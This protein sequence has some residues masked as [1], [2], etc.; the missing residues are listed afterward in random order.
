MGV[1]LERLN[2]EHTTESRQDCQELVL[3]TISY[4]SFYA[5]YRLNFL[6]AVLH[7]ERID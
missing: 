5:I 1:E 7:G 4:L 3:D 2:V 6:F